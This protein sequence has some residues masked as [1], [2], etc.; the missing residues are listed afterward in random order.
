MWKN[1]CTH[2]SRYRNVLFCRRFG[3]IP[4]SWHHTGY[5]ESLFIIQARR[6]TW[7]SEVAVSTTKKYPAN[8]IAASFPWY[9]ISMLLLQV[10]LVD[11]T[12]GLK[13]GSK[14][15]QQVVNGSS[16]QTGATLLKLLGRTTL[17]M[18]THMI[19]IPPQLCLDLPS[20]RIEES[21]TFVYICLDLIILRSS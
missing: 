19:K 5:K 6:P 1:S 2:F 18:K 11:Q 3:N 14:G 9:Q 13:I 15:R 17:T 4:F 12:F 8:T 10:F 21:Y 16:I 20:C 7:S